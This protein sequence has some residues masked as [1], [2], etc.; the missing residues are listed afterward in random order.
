MHRNALPF[1]VNKMK[2]NNPQQK[3]TVSEASAVYKKSVSTFTSFEEM[4][5]AEAKTM[6]T[7]AG[8]N[9]LQN[10]TSLIRKIYAEELKKPMTKK[11]NINK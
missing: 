9:H 8:I 3:N 11:L 4:N 1:K 2:K 5:E 7:I 6:A 10:A